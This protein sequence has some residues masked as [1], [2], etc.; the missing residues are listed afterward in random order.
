M[1]QRVDTICQNL[2]VLSEINDGDK[3]STLGEVIELDRW[4]FFQPFSRWWYRQGSNL[5]LSI[6]ETN[7]QEAESLILLFLRSETQP[8]PS[9]P[10]SSEGDISVL[11]SRLKNGQ[12]ILRLRNAIGCALRGL[13]RLSS[14]YKD[15]P[16]S[17]SRICVLI[18]KGRNSLD[19]I[20]K[21]LASLHHPLN[22][23]PN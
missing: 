19:T 8:P 3:L 1:Q 21:L 11:A 6:V 18:S 17:R 14:S 23:L 22:P 16:A 9:P 4:S 7:M 20:D 10:T 15:Q 12:T 5:N 13:E 2:N